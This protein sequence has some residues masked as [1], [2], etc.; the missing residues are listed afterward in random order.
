[1]AGITQ[2]NYSL[3]LID[4]TKPDAPASILNPD[5]SRQVT[6]LYKNLPLENKTPPSFWDRY[7]LCITDSSAALR[8]FL[9]ALMP[10]SR[11]VQMI[12]RNMGILDGSLFAYFGIRFGIEGVREIIQAI[13]TRDLREGSFSISKAISGFSFG[14]L[15]LCL[16][17]LRIIK[18]LSPSMQEEAKELTPTGFQYL[19]DGTLLKISSLLLN[20]AQFPAMLAKWR[21]LS[22]FEN[23]FINALLNDEKQTGLRH[24]LDFLEMKLIPPN[25]NE[26]SDPHLPTRLVHNSQR[27]LG[28]N[29]AAEVA[30]DLSALKAEV[31]T[32]AF[33]KSELLLNKIFHQ[34]R[35]E[36]AQALL[37]LFITSST[38][39]LNF[40]LLKETTPLDADKLSFLGWAGFAVVLFLW[41]LH[42]HPLTFNA[43][44]SQD[45]SQL[46]HAPTSR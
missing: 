17:L 15:G 41:A 6:E 14:A 37:G 18:T 30:Q 29:L 26:I 46:Y 27:L 16:A 22:S 43:I 39:L 12:D 7:K 28:A 20:G 11:T 24:G 40:M 32:G 38:I 9:M 21:S 5:L 44:P 25:L 19:A 10:E 42:D 33:E 31:E 1:M 4:Y 36:E 2:A 23:A 35:K 3:E 34:I 13:K 8:C 45:I